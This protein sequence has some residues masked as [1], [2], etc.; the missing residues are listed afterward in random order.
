MK[1]DS[2]SPT[3]IDWRQRRQAAREACEALVADPEDGELLAI[4][5]KFASDPKWEVRKVVAEA[6][7]M[8]PEGVAKDMSALMA[9]ETHHMV[10]AA[11]RRSL[12]RRQ[13]GSAPT[14]GHEGLLQDEYDKIKIR[15]GQEAADAAKEMAEKST[16]LHLRAAVHDIRNIITALNPSKE[17]ATDPKHSRN[18]KRIIKGRSYLKRMLDMMDKYSAPLFVKKTSVSLCEVVEESLSSA[19]SMI[20]EE[21]YDPSRVAVSIDFVGNLKFLVARFEIVMALTNLIKNAIEAHGRKAGRINQGEVRIYC[22]FAEQ[23]LDAPTFL[24]IYIQDSGVGLSQTDLDDRMR[25]IPGNT[26]KEGGTGYGLPLCNRY[27]TAH[28]GFLSLRSRDGEGTTAKVSIPFNL[29]L[30]SM[31]EEYKIHL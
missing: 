26:S 7:I 1:S 16:S 17:L 12:S 31:N 13:L 20:Q 4:A 6:L 29:N 10:E 2:S 14:K 21:G 22:G 8:F 9:G 19:L 27:I 23:F 3:P 28:G 30:D 25:F 5:S 18:V 11:I 15:Y 24:E